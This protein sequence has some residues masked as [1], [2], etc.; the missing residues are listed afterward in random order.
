M[1]I[2]YASARA[3]WT[4][5]GAALGSVVL[6]AATAMALQPDEPEQVLAYPVPWEPPSAAAPPIFPSVPGGPGIVPILPTST[7]PAGDAPTGSAP[8][9]AG[10]TGP[11]STSVAVTRLPATHR[12]TT[13]PPYVPPP[14]VPPTYTPPPPSGP[15]LSLRYDGGADGSSKAYGRSFKDV[16]DGNMGTFWSPIGTTGEISVKWT[17][18]VTLSRIRIREAPGGGRIGSWRLRNHDNGA[19]LASGNGAGTITFGRVTLRKITFI[20]LDAAGTP[21]VGEYETYAH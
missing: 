13:P 4:L 12:P 11:A 8:G 19:I 1:T 17:S 18:P 3:R 16:R 21:R 7:P 5:I 15:N 14:Y 20:V 6:L 10:P 9:G 2:W